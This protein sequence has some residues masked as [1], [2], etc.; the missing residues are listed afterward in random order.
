MSAR[1]LIVLA[2]ILVIVGGFYYLDRS[3]LER[4]KKQEEESKQIVPVKAEDVARVKIERGGEVFVAERAEGDRWKIREPYQAAG[5]RAT[6]QSLVNN[7]GN[8]QMQR[9]LDEPGDL[10]NYGLDQPKVKVSLI[11]REA[12]EEHTILFGNKIPSGS[13]YYAQRQGEPAVFTVYSYIFTSA[14]KNLFEFTDKSLLDFEP[15]DVRSFEVLA[16]GTALVLDL[17]SEK[18]ARMLEP[19]RLPADGD[20]VRALLWKIK[21]GRVAEFGPRKVPQ[22]DLAQYGLVDPATRVVLGFGR[23]GSDRSYKGLLIGDATTTTDGKN[24]FWAMQEGGSDVFLIEE[25]TA[26]DMYRNPDELRF[27]QLGKIR[28]WEAKYF[29]LN[30]HGESIILTKEDTEWKMTSPQELPGKREGITDFLGKFAGYNGFKVK[31]YIMSATDLP[32]YHLAEPPYKV[33]VKGDQLEE[34][35]TVS[36][37]ILEKDEAGANLRRVYAQ[38]GA[39]PDVVLVMEETQPILD[40]LESPLTEFGQFPTPTPGPASTPMPVPTVGA[41]EEEAPEEAGDVGSATAA[42]GAEEGAETGE[43]G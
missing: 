31:D 22:A 25:T 12:S 15:N 24:R 37:L 18:G 21:N 35:Y 4:A 36:D 34:T 9:K 10:R 16:G 43:G 42:P 13:D 14:D 29:E 32:R 19:Y 33:V 5:D 30:R 17:P 39:Y 40:M 2:V 20:D 23:E 41:V 27:E 11:T 6:F 8:G 1:K 3:R 38:W 7:I 28:D 26:K